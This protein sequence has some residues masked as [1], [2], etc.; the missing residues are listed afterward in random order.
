MERATLARPYAE[1]L[2]NLAASSGAWRL[3]SERLA[4]LALVVADA[5]VAGLAANP[6]V[7]AKRVAELITSVCGDRLGVEGNNLVHVLAENKRLELLPEIVEQFEAMKAEQDGVLEAHVAT[8]YEL[9]PA[10]MAA[11]VAKLETK[12]ARKVNA[13]QTVDAD[14]IGGVVIRV[15]DEVMD[16]SVRGGLDGLAT[17]LKA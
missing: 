2:A 7:P 12:F 17:S 5:Q 4:Q 15:G 3:W 10:Q 11:L 9:S 8:A 13:S 16:A 1:A 14:L 6:S